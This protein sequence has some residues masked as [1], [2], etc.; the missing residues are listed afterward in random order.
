MSQSSAKVLFRMKCSHQ[1]PYHFCTGCL[2]LDQAY[3]STTDLVHLRFGHH[4][5]QPWCSVSAIVTYWDINY[6]Q[7]TICQ[8][9]HLP[10]M[11][12]AVSRRTRG[13]SWDEVDQMSEFPKHP[14]KGDYLKSAHDLHCKSRPE[15]ED[16]R[17]LSQ[18]FRAGA[19]HLLFSYR[20]TLAY[21]YQRCTL[22][23]LLPLCCLFF[24]NWNTAA[25][26]CYLPNITQLYPTQKL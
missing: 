15:R 16:K 18:C 3:S 26:L 8:P 23:C 25:V 6:K 12:T 5:T 19:L 1:S 2:D 21:G 10:Q 11:S 17:R 24:S 20:V 14:S 4:Q 13:I 7:H 22:Q 9:L